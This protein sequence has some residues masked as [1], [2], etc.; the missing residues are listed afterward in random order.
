MKR[1]A[2]A[3][4]AL[5]PLACA[6]LGGDGRGDV[7]LPTSGVGP[8]RKLGSGEVQGTAP[9]LLDDQVAHWRDAAALSL[10]G[11]AVALYA[12]VD[13]D[14]AGESRQVI[15]R[16]RSTDG[17]SFYGGRGGQIP[18]VSILGDA[19]W[20]GKVVSGPSPLQVGSETW[21]YYAAAG[22]IG[23]ARSSDGIA[24]TKDAQ[25]VLPNDASHVWHSPSVARFPDGSFHLLVVSGNAFSEMTSSD[26]VTFTA[27][28]EALA[29]RTVATEAGV[30]VEII[31][32]PVALV[33]T[34]AAG[35]LHFRVLYTS[36]I[37]SVSA[38]ALAARY[39]DTGPLS[40]STNGPVY[41]ATET[42]HG[43]AAVE[44]DGYTLLYVTDVRRTTTYP[45]IA[46]AVSPA[47][48][49]LPTADDY[50]VSP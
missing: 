19:P 35:R 29:E 37:G 3:V 22:G 40:R 15:V 17:R 28:I 45:S 14:V 12:V 21:L 10:G 34:T 2:L 36:T 31:D 20:E 8:F 11:T 41:S 47:T 44:L 1:H 5:L 27:P 7:D 23:R 6:T 46:G 26:G 30:V 50:P 33:R 24:F 13:R 42:Q 38:I 43:P 48:I 4:L 49:T 9:F 16:T 32:D 25:P 18:P 39:G